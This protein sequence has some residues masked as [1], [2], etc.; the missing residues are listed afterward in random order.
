MPSV[1][2]F[3]FLR[4]GGIFLYTTMEES[5]LSEPLSDA[6][7]ATSPLGLKARCISSIHSC[8]FSG[9]SDLH[10]SDEDA[11]LLVRGGG[12]GPSSA[13]SS[14]VSLLRPRTE[15]LSEGAML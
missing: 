15:T 3:L 11:R 13:R 5:S 14:E 4:T 9:L 6:L 7:T 8:V 2:I 12:V 10:P 1:L